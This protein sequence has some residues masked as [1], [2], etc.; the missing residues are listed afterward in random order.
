MHS[1]GLG[2]STGSIVPPYDSTTQ[3]I[4]DL[5]SLFAN[6][7]NARNFDAKSSPWNKVTPSFRAQPV[8]A[9]N[10]Q[11]DVHELL[12]HWR[13]VFEEFPNMFVR[14]VDRYTRLLDEG[15]LAENYETLEIMN[16]PE[17]VIKQMIGRCTWVFR[18]GEWRIA[19]YKAMNGMNPA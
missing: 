17:G 13:T 12:A 5:T 7:I 1:M 10:R 11:L 8:F 15:N 9:E 3:N 18:E 14:T 4:E 6:A 2:T 19:S 16:A